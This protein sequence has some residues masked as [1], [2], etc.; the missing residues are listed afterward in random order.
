MRRS[1]AIPVLLPIFLLLTGAGG[2]QSTGL[3]FLNLVGLEKDP[4]VIALVAQQ[5]KSGPEVNP[6]ALLNP[7][8]PYERLQ[9]AL[10]AELGRPVAWDLCFPV[11]LEPGLNTGFFHLALIS[12]LEYA[13]LPQPE[14][15]TVVA[16]P[17]DERGQVARPA[18]LVV[19]ADSAIQSVEDLRGKTVA[20]GPAN[21]SRTH[22]AALE[23]LAQH[24]LKP[25]DLSLELLPLPGSL[26]HMPN[27]RAVAQSVMHASSDAGFID[28]AAWEAFPELAERED[29]PAR[30][31]LRV[32]AKTSAVPEQLVVGSP[33]LDQA[34]M[35]K[36]RAALLALERA[37]PEA[38]RPLHV[39][40]YQVPTDELI[41]ACRRLTEAGAATTRP[42]GAAGLPVP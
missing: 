35:E 22:A 34:V 20:F 28:A 30:G 31:R 14:R 13:R 26:K 37:H 33:K 16:V 36:V 11:Q 38:L 29:D 27:M 21:D 32:I 39:S 2:C 12:P 9:S 3:R 19:A 25:G 23:L 4:L 18:V 17:A 7:F 6:L 41:Q 5:Q 42:A 1:A 8:G 40:S 24:G 10:R 15:F